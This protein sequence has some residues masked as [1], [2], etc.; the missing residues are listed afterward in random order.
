MTS[1]FRGIIES[2]DVIHDHGQC[3][4]LGFL[5][6]DRVCRNTLSFEDADHSRD[7]IKFVPHDSVPRLPNLGMDFCDTDYRGSGI[8]HPEIAGVS[9]SD[10]LRFVNVML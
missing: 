8:C 7:N 6:G 10:T 5:K 1:L 3:Q 4:H 2:A 9:T